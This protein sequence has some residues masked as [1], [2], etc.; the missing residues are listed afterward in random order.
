[1]KP[2]V[3][4]LTHTIHENLSVFPGDCEIEME[5]VANVK[6]DGYSNSIVKM[7]MHIG[8]H[9]DG[10][11]HMIDK[12]KRIDEISASRFISNAYVVDVRGCKIINRDCMHSVIG[13]IKPNDSVLFYTGWSDLFGKDD[14]YKDYPVIDSE[15]A[16]VLV[17][18]GVGIVGLDSPSPDM[19]PFEVHRIFMHNEVLIIENLCNLQL[20]PANTKFELFAFPLKFA[21]DSSPARVVARVCN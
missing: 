15:L 16:M 19:D 10:P 8:T 18:K 12:A 4:D 14:Y 7:G 1:M 21:C 5:N 6:D 2:Q 9:I 17:E 13:N 3:I 11:L 20:I